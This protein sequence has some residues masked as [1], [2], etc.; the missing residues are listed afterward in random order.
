MFIC[1]YALKYVSMPVCVCVHVSSYVRMFVC[2]HVCMY[3]CLFVRLRLNLHVVVSTYA[4]VFV[5]VYVC[6]C[7]DIRVFEYVQMFECV[8]RMCIC[9]YARVFVCVFAF[10]YRYA[11]FAWSVCHAF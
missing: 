2:M 7:L 10:M 8:L 11:W 1:V 5:Y 3:V 6:R 9:F 4:D